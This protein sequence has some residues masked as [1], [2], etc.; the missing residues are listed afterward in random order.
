MYISL[1]IYYSIN[2]LGVYNV[3]IKSLRAYF[4]LNYAITSLNSCIIY[5]PC[6]CTSNAWGKYFIKFQYSS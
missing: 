4:N 2:D 6:T 1:R 3:Y 5:L